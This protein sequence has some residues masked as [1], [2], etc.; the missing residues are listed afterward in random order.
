VAPRPVG[1]PGQPG[2]A[3]PAGPTPNG[4]RPAAARTDNNVQPAERRG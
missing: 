4:T 3:R 1:P 2:E